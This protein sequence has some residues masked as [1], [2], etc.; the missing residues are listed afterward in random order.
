MTIITEDQMKERLREA[1]K[2]AGGQAAFGR[3]IGVSRQFIGQILSGHCPASKAVCNKIHL[4][5]ETRRVYVVLPT[6]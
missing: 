5:G 3:E 6:P 2:A 1:C 4:T